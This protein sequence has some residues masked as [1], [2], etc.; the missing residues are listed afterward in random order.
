MWG[1]FTEGQSKFNVKKNPNT[2]FL[3]MPMDKK[4]WRGKAKYSHAKGEGED[5]EMFNNQPMFRYNAYFSINTVHYMDL[6]QTY[7]KESLPLLRITQASL[8]TKAAKLLVRTW[9]KDRILK[10]WAEG[11]F[12]RM[13]ALKFISYIDED[14]FPEIIPL[15]HGQ[16]SNNIRL[17]FYP[18][19]FR[20]ELESIPK[21]SSVA[22]FGLTMEMESV[23][24]RGTFLGIK[25]PLA[26]S[27]GVIDVEWVYNSMPPKSE[28]IYPVNKIQPVVNF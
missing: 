25:L 27:L 23:L 1:Q 24:I 3:V 17:T 10:P 16:A 13:D 11:V 26:I 19:A 9:K 20:K 15:I 18:A 4:L 6:V 8:I 21:S 5:Y 7:G 12:N 14:G 28:Q 22:V 2:A